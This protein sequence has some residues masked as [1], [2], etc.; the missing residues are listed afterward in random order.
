MQFP[1]M[2]GVR[3]VELSN[4]RYGSKFSVL[5]C[6]KF[7]VRMYR[8]A[9]LR[10]LLIVMLWPSC[11]ETVKP[12][13]DG[14]FRFPPNWMLIE[15]LREEASQIDVLKEPVL[16]PRDGEPSGQERNDQEKNGQLTP[17]STDQPTED[18]QVL[19]DDS[20]T[21]CAHLSKREVC[22]RALWFILALGMSIKVVTSHRQV[23]LFGF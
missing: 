4:Q 6:S 23:C 22:I 8:C 5:V 1:A 18:Q 13:G 3:R 15:H 11:V 19:A 2:S 9:Q 21:A 12:A 17:L 14:G 7:H 16:Q 20:E 10:A